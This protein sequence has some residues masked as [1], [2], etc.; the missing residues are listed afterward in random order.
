MLKKATGPN[1]GGVGSWLRRKFTRKGRPAESGDLSGNEGP[2]TLADDYNQ[3]DYDQEASGDL[4]Y[5]PACVELNEYRRESKRRF[6]YLIPLPASIA[7]KLTPSTMDFRVRTY[8]E[9]DKKLPLPGKT[10]KGG[11]LSSN[12]KRRKQIVDYL[13]SHDKD[14]RLE[15]FLAP[16]HDA[17]L[18][19]LGGNIEVEQ[20]L[21]KDKCWRGGLA[22]AISRRHWSEQ[23]MIVTRDQLIL[24][25]S[26]D[27][28]RVVISI[29]IADILSVRAVLP[30]LCPL[31]SVGFLEVETH[32]RV[33]T[34]MV[35]SDMQINGWLEAFV[36]L[37]IMPTAEGTLA[38]RG[39]RTGNV[40]REEVYIARPACWKTDKKR[41]YNYR[42]IQF[43]GLASPQ[44]NE[45]I[46]RILATAFFL[47]QADA[48]KLMD[49]EWQR[50][51]DDISLLQAV[52]LI[53]LT[54]A[55]RLAFFLNLY[56]VMVLH[57]CLMFGPPPAWNHW[58]A[59]FNNI[60]Y[61]V[62]FEL[63]SIAEIE[64]CVLRAAM[65]K[66]SLFT[67][68][69]MPAPPQTALPTLAMHAHKDFRLHFAINCGSLSLLAQVPIYTAE[70]LDQQLDDVSTPVSPF[71]AMPS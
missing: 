60:S 66:S 65:A 40:Y 7:A 33:F 27:S 16:C 32:T 9:I 14:R 62:S 30:E 54:D 48:G 29:A 37:G 53:N 23:F 57:G 42:R 44:P 22:V 31:D 69:A 68:V 19:F 59:F 11:R 70:R 67:A 46:E 63:V 49:S 50:F 56:H 18:H 45:L 35:R 39:Q 34:F 10:D 38:R 58:N 28:K 1:R 61:V 6:Y 3:Q 8:S 36:T 25:R 51:W 15:N 43:K 17:D 71:H 64:Y 52:N 4:A 12:E 24:Q 20:D 21:S 5:C 41:V 13:A 2:D 55:Q 47:C 26:R